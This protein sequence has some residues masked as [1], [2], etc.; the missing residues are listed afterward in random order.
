MVGV[1]ACRFLRA[2]KAPTIAAGVCALVLLVTGDPAATAAVR[3]VGAEP[4]RAV[5]AGTAPSA[6]LAFAGEDPQPTT[7]GDEAATGQEQVVADTTAYPARA[8]GTLTFRFP[9]GDPG[10]CTAFLVDKNSVI[11][12]AHCVHRGDGDVPAAW[13][14]DIEFDPGHNGAVT[15]YRTCNGVDAFAPEPWRVDGAETSDFAVVQLDCGIGRRVGWF[16]L[17]LSGRGTDLDGRVVK[18]RGYPGDLAGAQWRGGGR[19][20]ASTPRLVFHNARTLGDAAGGPL[21]RVTPACG[22]PCAVAVQ[23]AE[24]HGSGAG[25]HAQFAH[26]PRFSRHRFA[27]VL[28]WA[29]ENG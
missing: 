27:Q 17:W 10:T 28:G 4:A 20:T 18:V 8:V 12:A 1:G 16:G 9:S 21:Y 3:P 7:G 23:A 11:T 13:S 6:G 2:V 5:P 14:T 22:G 25:V 29:A 26:G 19:V 15:P 24:P